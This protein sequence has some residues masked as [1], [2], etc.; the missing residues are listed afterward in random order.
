MY[1]EKQRYTLLLVRF[2]EPKVTHMKKRK[3]KKRKE[4]KSDWGLKNGK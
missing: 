1:F 3:E 4:K 2:R